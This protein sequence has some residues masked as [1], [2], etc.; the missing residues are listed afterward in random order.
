VRDKDT[1]VQLTFKSAK[2]GHTYSIIARRHIPIRTWDVVRRYRLLHACICG[3]IG[4]AVIER[5]R[6]RERESLLTD[7]SLRAFVMGARALTHMHTDSISHH[8]LSKVHSINSDTSE[9]ASVHT[10]EKT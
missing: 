1:G 7:M 8:E 6:E 4:L 3:C 10:Q 5:E 9:Y 2:D